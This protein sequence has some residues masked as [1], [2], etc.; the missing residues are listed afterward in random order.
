V[1]EAGPGLLAAPAAKPALAPRAKNKP[2]VPAGKSA[3]PVVAAVLAPPQG[4]V[5]LAV[6]PWGRVEVDGKPTGITPPLSSLS[7]PLGTHQITLRNDD[8]PAHTATVTVTEDKAVVVRH[9]FGS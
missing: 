5:Q 7:L 3:P 2:V 8:F 1:V 6:S 9:R 4:L